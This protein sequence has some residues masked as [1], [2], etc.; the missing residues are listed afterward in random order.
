MLR[1]CWPFLARMRPEVAA[2]VL[3]GMTPESAYAV[4]LTIA[5]RNHG[6]PVQ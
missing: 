2:N 3:T 1:Q 4:T 5:S 6:V